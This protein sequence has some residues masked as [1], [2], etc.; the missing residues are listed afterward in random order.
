MGEKGG[1]GVLMVGGGEGEHS[2]DKHKY[3]YV[4]QV[5]RRALSFT[6]RQNRK[7]VSL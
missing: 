2:K 3:I 1:V 7:N 6:Q 5:S 4:G